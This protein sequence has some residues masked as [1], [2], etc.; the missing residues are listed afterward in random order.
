MTQAEY[1][2]R[3]ARREFDKVGT[4]S[5]S[6]VFNLMNAGVDAVALEESFLAEKA[7]EEEQ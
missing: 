1:A 4:L 2:I 3:L 5:V 6:T 7:S